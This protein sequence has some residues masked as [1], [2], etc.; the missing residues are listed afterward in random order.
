MQRPYQIYNKSP[1][2]NYTGYFFSKDP[3]VASS[4]KPPRS[5]F[6]P[7]RPTMYIP[8][9]IDFLFHCLLLSQKLFC[10][11]YERELLIQFPKNLK[12]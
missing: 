1:K 9:K 5:N 6:S 10:Q 8:A 4:R 3:E 12:S 7:L 11:A 2:T